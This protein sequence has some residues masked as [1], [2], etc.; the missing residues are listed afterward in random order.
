MPEVLD[1]AQNLESTT[2][3]INRTS[4]TVKGGRRL[5]FS[6]LV[7]VGNRNGSVGVGYGKGRGVPVAIE[8]AQKAAR[9]NLFRVKMNRGTIH[10]AVLGRFLASQVKLIPAAPGTGVIAGGTV[11]AVLE[12]AGVHDCLTKAYGSTTK[13]NLCKAVVDALKQLRSRDEIVKLR[14]VDL[15]SSTIDEMLDATSAAAE[16]EA[17]SAPKAAKPVAI[18]TSKPAADPVT[19]EPEVVEVKGDTAT[20]KPGSE[21]DIT[22]NPEAEKPAD[23]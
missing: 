3:E 12:M 18:K 20:I 11:R 16:A 1:E 6:A 19:P 10:H 14:G 21:A 7:V 8:K 15:A 17:A 13:A 2:V 22:E 5:S 9:R 4:T 23:A